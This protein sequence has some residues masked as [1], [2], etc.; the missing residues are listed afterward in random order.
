VAVS[1]VTRRAEASVG[2]GIGGVEV[3]DLAAVHRQRLPAGVPVDRSHV[4]GG[5]LLAFLVLRDLVSD[6]F[7]AEGGESIERLRRREI[8]GPE[9]YEE[10]GGVLASDMVSDV[11]N[12]FLFDELRLWA[13][14]RGSRYRRLV[15]RVGGG[16]YGLS[17][18]WEAYDRLAPLLDEEFAQ[19]RRRRWLYNLLRY[20][21]APAAF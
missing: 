1:A 12:E 5:Q 4:H 2:G 14:N 13:A 6:W 8:T 16:P 21:Q 11:G 7:A 15:V 3:Y 10:W 9:L 18:S 20:V 17:S 19:W